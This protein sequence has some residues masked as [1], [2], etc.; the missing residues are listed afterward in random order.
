MM[1]HELFK[2]LA[3]PIRLR[4]AVLLLDQE[5][6]VCDLME[7]LKVPQST[8]SRHMSRMKSA[9]L[10]TD[11]RSGKWVHYQLANTP[12]VNELRDF[13]ARHLAGTN[14]FRQDLARLKKYVINRKCV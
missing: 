3:D 6:C 9:G 2:G 10:V 8:V 4:I 5:L 14:P 12:Q 13:L 7:V 1:T 11:R